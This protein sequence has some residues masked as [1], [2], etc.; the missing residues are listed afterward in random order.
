MA[1]A[2]RTAV[3]KTLTR[4][5]N[6]SWTG[7]PAAPHLT[8]L[9]LALGPLAPGLQAQGTGGTPLGVQA[10]AHPFGLNVVAP[11]MAGGSDDASARFQQNILPRVTD[12]LNARLSESTRINDSALALDPSRLRLQ[13]DSDVRV[14]FIGEGASYHNTLGFNT[15]GSGVDSGNPQLIFPD[16]SSSVSTYDPAATARRNGANPLLPGDFVNLGPQAGGTLL[17]FFLIANGASGGRSTFS[18][19]Q[20]ANPDGINHVVAFAYAIPGSSLLI[21]GFEDLFGGGD[22]DFN[23]LLFAVDIGAANIAALTG[24]P[25]PMLCLTLGGL[26]VGL[27]AVKR[28]QGRL[29]T[30][31]ALPAV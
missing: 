25:E 23:D 12:F 20:S 15:T 27:I 29:T 28:R 17:N 16:A 6:N 18:T 21:I 11:V 14:Y 13:T 26:V 4:T 10:A 3:M 2:L 31:P 5:N 9:L 19:D 8:A 24:T 1:P 22:G 7:R 30:V